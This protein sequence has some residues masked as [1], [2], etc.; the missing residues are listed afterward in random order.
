MRE[1]RSFI[2]KNFDENGSEFREWLPSD[3][4]PNIAIFTKIRVSG[5][6]L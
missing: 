5:V 6:I 4:K 3:W 2:N 1:L